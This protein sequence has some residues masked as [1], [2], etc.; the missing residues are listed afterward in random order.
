MTATL[1]EF[2]DLVR[3]ALL[4]LYDVGY[5]QTHPLLTLVEQPA[6]GGATSGP[7]LR[8]VLLD[9]IEALRP[10]PDVAPT[11]R[12]WRL[13]H[14]LELRYVECH[15]VAEVIEQIALSSAQ[16]HREHHRALEMV[17][18]MLR[19]R[20]SA[21]G[22]GDPARSA[23]DADLVRR[24]AEELLHDQRAGRIDLAQIV[25]EIQVLLRPL[26]ADRIVDLQI[27]VANHLS[28]IAGERV[29]VRQLLLALL[30]HCVTAVDRGT[31]AV[32]LTNQARQ[33]GVTISGP[34]TGFVD[35][36]EVGLAASRPFVEALRA[37]VR[38]LPAPTPMAPWTIQ[39]ALP[40]LARPTL[41]VV[42]NHADFVR[43]VGLYLTG[44]D[45]DVIGTTTVDEAVRVAQ[46]R[47]PTVIL[48]DVIIPGR[49]GWD[50]LLDLRGHP[51]TLDIPVIICSV[52]R[53]P[54]MAT[55]LGA[56]A[57]L[58]K[59]VSQPELMAALRPYH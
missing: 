3:D 54:Q 23:N 13:H 4:H 21:A 49:D 52:L 48:L 16:Y 45:W 11:A 39:V 55:A 29:A 5:L 56:T 37:T 42:D 57:Y 24:E 9:A 27:E 46:Q 58:Q 18:V 41:L 14:I 15:D 1:P 17:A 32:R 12:A 53:E 30:S 20:S 22:A 7:R 2:T 8:Q 36:I 59:P 33:V 44:S 28:A 31:I 6:G 40:A 50:L 10:S 34:T 47:H 19:E 35:H 26:R 51:A 43:L 25:Q 38:F